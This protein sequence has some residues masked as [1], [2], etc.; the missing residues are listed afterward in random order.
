MVRVHVSVR[1]CR[2]AVH[3]VHGVADARTQF[4]ITQLTAV[5]VG[6]G[7]VGEVLGIVVKVHTALVEMPDAFFAT[8]F[9]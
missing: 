5:L 4:D 9:Q 3:E 2:F 1:V 7:A 8:I 6:G